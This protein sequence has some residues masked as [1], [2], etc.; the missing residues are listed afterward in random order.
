M[1]DPLNSSVVRSLV[2]LAYLPKHRLDIFFDQEFEYNE[3]TFSALI[4]N[5]MDKQE[6]Y[7]DKRKSVLRQ[8]TASFKMESINQDDS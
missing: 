7:R 5:E 1:D 2:S 4:Y 8:A 3:S 6:K